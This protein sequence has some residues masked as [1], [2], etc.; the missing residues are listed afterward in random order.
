[1]NRWL[2]PLYQA[3]L[4]TLWAIALIHLFFAPSSWSASAWNAPALATAGLLVA[5]SAPLAFFIGL[6]WFRWE[7]I[8]PHPV[9]VSVLSGLG[10]VMI[11]MAIY[12]YGDQHP[13]WMLSALATLAGWMLYLR[14]VKVQPEAGT[15]DH[16]PDAG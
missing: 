4:L 1:M 13:F 10:A 12:R 7:R 14:V 6:R 8:E 11:M 9:W 2:T 3:L 16:P 5:T 15:T